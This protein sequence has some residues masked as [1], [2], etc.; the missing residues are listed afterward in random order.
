MEREQG[1]LDCEGSRERKEEQY[2]RCQTEVCPGEGNEI[3]RELSGLLVVDRCEHDDPDQ[4]ERGSEERVKEELDRSRRPPLE[5][6][7][8]DH[9]VGRDERQ[10]EED[11]EQDE[12]ERDEAPE[13]S[14]LEYE[15]PYDERSRVLLLWCYG[16][17][18][19]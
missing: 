10:L 6:P 12:I 7:A 9:E 8:R 18:E 14:R 4:H 19:R 2:L 13:T 1:G 11:E 17:R 16:Q 3:E 15:H 5:T